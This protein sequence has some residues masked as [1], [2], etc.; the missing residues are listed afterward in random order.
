MQVR[1]SPTASGLVNGQVTASW[2]SPGLS[3]NQTS[4]YFIG[5]TGV[6]PAQLNF[7]STV[8]AFGDV[9]TG[10]VAPLSVTVRNIGGTSGSIATAPIGGADAASFTATNNCGGSI[11]PN[12]TCTVSVSFLPQTTR[13]GYSATLNLTG[14]SGTNTGPG[15]TLSG[16]GIRPAPTGSITVSPT[17]VL[18]PGTRGDVG[19]VQITW[20]SQN[21][22]TCRVNIDAPNS[23]VSPYLIFTG[24]SGSQRYQVPA[25]QPSNTTENHVFFLTCTGRVTAGPWASAS[26]T[27][28]K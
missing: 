4:A 1:F 23:L 19:Y 11:A 27:V 7:T 14:T 20:S 22:D 25:M 13:N 6:S 9:V 21:A 16:N 26:V 10:S 18:D 15:I 28:S 5:G 17:S 3:G 8:L 12:G 2:T 24:V